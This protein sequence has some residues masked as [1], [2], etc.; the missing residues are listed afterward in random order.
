[1]SDAH[2]HAPGSPSPAEHGSTE[3]PPVPA[4]R[5]ITPAPEDYRSPFPGAGVAW[6]FFWL[7]L[8]LLLYAAAAGGPGPIERGEH[9]A[10][11][12]APA[13]PGHGGD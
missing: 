13:A 1:M 4:T 10:S 3:F 7:L 6:P 2:G 5:W 8:G 11:H 9:G 12:E